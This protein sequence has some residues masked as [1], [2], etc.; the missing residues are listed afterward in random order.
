MLPPPLNVI[1]AAAWPWDRF[2]S[3]TRGPDDV[4]DETASICGTVSD[5]AIGTV[6]APLSLSP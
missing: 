2:Y 3:W 1:S 6:T 5:R 4:D